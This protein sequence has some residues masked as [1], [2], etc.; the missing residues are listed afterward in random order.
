MIIGVQNLSTLVSTQDAYD[1][2]LLI[3]RQLRDHVAP[4][5]GLLPPTV[6]FLAVAPGRHFDAI[7]GILD[8]ADQAGDLGW[9]SEGPD[10]N[11][12]GRVFAR[13][14]LDNGG[15]ALT[16]SLSVCSVLSHEAIEVLGDPAC[17]LWAQQPSGT[18]VAR[19]LCDPVEGDSYQLAVTASSGESVTGTVSDFVLPSWFD[20][21]AAPGATD[22]LGLVTAPFQVRSTGYTIV[23]SAG[24]V[25]EQWGEHYPDWRKDTKQSSLARTAQRL[26]LAVPVV[27]TSPLLEPTSLA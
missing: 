21:A 6:T 11:V 8:N 27:L 25:T 13:P 15:N 14:V 12:Y 5:W 18:L 10:A 16:G 23:M 24:S 19:E 9:H 17:D 7:I 1:M 26:K 4:A 22:Y 20:P 2:T 3:D